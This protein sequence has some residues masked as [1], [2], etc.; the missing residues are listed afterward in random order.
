MQIRQPYGIVGTWLRGD[1]IQTHVVGRQRTQPSLLHAVVVVIQAVLGF[2]H[3]YQSLSL[4]GLLLLAG[5]LGRFGR[6][7]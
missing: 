3:C 4:S 2:G 1:E 6:R 7:R 5:Q